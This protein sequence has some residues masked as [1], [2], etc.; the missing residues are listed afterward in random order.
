MPF[1]SWTE[2]QYTEADWRAMKS[3][4]ELVISALHVDVK[5]QEYCERLARFVMLVF[6]RGISD[7][8]A[9]AEK[10]VQCTITGRRNA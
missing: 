8:Q 3:A 6:S 10:V 5:N 4:Y 7:P 1:R 2:N 9:I